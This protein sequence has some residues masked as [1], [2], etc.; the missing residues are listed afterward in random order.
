MSLQ[1]SSL[2]I[3]NAISCESC[4]GRNSKG[5]LDWLHYWTLSLSRRQRKRSDGVVGYWRVN[6]PTNKQ[7]RSRVLGLVSE[8]QKRGTR[9]LLIAKPND[10]ALWKGM[11][12]R[13]HV[14]FCFLL[15][16]WR[17]PP[18]ATWWGLIWLTFYRLSGRK[19]KTGNRRQKLKQRPWSLLSY[20]LLDHPSRD[21]T[22][23]NKTRLSHSNHKWRKFSWACLQTNEV[24]SSQMILECVELTKSWPTLGNTR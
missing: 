1:P 7:F 18:K 2:H 22:I 3:L 20:V 14:L 8:K 13:G 9:R 23:H 16:W 10:R 24:P 12:I 6:K 17:P 15:L 5:K 11:Q 21:G 4:I 19:A